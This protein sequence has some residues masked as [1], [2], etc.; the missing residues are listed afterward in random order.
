M[1]HLAQ[2]REAEGGTCCQTTEGPS[3]A[4]DACSVKHAAFRWVIDGSAEAAGGRRAG[5]APL[6]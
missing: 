6:P 2:W 1:Q 3:S 4:G 5:D